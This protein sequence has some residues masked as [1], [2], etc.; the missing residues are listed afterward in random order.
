MN[1][2][3][4][5]RTPNGGITVIAIRDGKTARDEVIEFLSSQG[6]PVTDEILR[7]LA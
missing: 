2:T 4:S 5:V 7:Q 6:I 1:D 3:V